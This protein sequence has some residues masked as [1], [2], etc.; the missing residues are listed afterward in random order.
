MIA[1]DRDHLARALGSIA[2]RPAPGEAPFV[3]VEVGP[4]VH[5]ALRDRGYAVRRG[6]TFPGLDGGWV[7]IAVRDPATSDAL[8][9]ALAEVGLRGGARP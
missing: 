9:H 8:V 2:L 5:A 6:D 1:R 3:L 4:G 7:R